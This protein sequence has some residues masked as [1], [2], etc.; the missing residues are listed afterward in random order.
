LGL[1]WKPGQARLFYCRAQ[2]SSIE[3]SEALRSIDI[4]REEPRR[5]RAHGMRKLLF[6][7]SLIGLGIYGLAEQT[8]ITDL[9]T[10]TFPQNLARQ[11]ALRHCFADDRYF[12]R[13]SATARTACY[14]KYLAASEVRL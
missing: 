2:W 6:P 13:S 1:R 10:A 5:K 8:T 9:L 4:E 12:N 11:A 7:L 3:L 14:E